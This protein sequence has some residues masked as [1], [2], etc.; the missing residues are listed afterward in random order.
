M[1]YPDDLNN[2][3]IQALTRCSLVIF[4][5][6]LG[7]NGQI[8]GL[9]FTV[10]LQKLTLT[11]T[12]HC[13]TLPSR[14]KAPRNGSAVQIGLWRLTQ[15]LP[16]RMRQVSTLRLKQLLRKFCLFR[17]RRSRLTLMPRGESGNSAGN[18]LPATLP[19][20]MIRKPRFLPPCRSPP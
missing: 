13:A 12:H 17:T 5:P 4:E 20:Q 6:W 7:Q 16:P 9:V 3:G 10:N 14:R 1:L 2:L 18:G 15:N 8:P 11:F 19:A